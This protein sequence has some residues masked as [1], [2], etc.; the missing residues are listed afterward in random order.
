MAL[1]VLDVVEL[2]CQRVVDVDD[3]DLPVGLLFVE[4]GHDAEDLDLL[5]LARV[6][7]EL[8]DLAHVERVVVALGLGLGMDDIGVLPGLVKIM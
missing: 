3:D 6:A 4:E 8:A 5:D 2:R 7:D 1:D